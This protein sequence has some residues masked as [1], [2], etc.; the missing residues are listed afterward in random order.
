MPNRRN[1][2]S[3]EQIPYCNGNPVTG[4]RI[5]NLFVTDRRAGG[6][7]VDIVTTYATSRWS[8]HTMMALPPNTAIGRFKFTQCS[9]K[10]FHGMTCGKL[11]EP[12]TLVTHQTL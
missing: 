10:S 6:H 12:R 5:Y 3:S 7:T 4:H 9:P 2:T 11:E 1:G 8:R